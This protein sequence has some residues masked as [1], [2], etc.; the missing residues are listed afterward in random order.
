MVNLYLMELIF[1]VCVVTYYNTS[2]ELAS[3]HKGDIFVKLAE[4]MRKYIV[5]RYV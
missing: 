3:V 4:A 1:L 5:M 2:T